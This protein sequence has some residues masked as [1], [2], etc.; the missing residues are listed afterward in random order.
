MSITVSIYGLH[1]K[2]KCTAHT[3]DRFGTSQSVTR[4]VDLDASLNYQNVLADAAATVMVSI[5]PR[6]GG[7]TFHVLCSCDLELDPMT[8]IYES[9]PYTEDLP[10][11]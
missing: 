8:F 9:D 1:W 4:R 2:E 7:I 10:A 11:D 3:R 6:S 5:S